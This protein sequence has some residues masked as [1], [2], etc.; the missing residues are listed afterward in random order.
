[1]T[2][3][4]GDGPTETCFQLYWSNISGVA[5]PPAQKKI[6]FRRKMA[7]NCQLFAERLHERFVRS[8]TTAGVGK[9]PLKRVCSCIGA[10]YRGLQGRQHK[11]KSFRPKMAKNCQ[12][13]AENS[14]FLAGVV[15][16]RAPYPILRVPNPVRCVWN[17]IGATY[18]V[19]QGR[20]HRKKQF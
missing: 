16:F 6:S 7:S 11:K 20:Q 18:W 4:V 9:D 14:V 17:C 8:L 1:M 5:G 13:F 19:L 12:F 10:T 3:G 2:A 15:S